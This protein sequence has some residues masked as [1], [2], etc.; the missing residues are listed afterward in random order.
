V[1]VCPDVRILVIEADVAAARRIAELL[2]RAGHGTEI[3]PDGKGGLARLRATQFDAVIT[4]WMLPDVDGTSVIREIRAAAGSQPQTILVSGLSGPLIRAHAERVG[5]DAFFSKPVPERP[6]LDVIASR[7][8]KRLMTAP[9]SK[10]E[11]DHPVTNSS[12]WGA[13]MDTLGGLLSESTGIGWSLATGRPID[14]TVRVSMSMISV[15]HL[16]E[17]DLCL[18]ASIETGRALAR[19]MLRDKS[20]TLP[21]MRDLLRDL[22]NNLLGGLKTSLEKEGFDFT[23]SLADKGVPPGPREF[24]DSLATV[25]THTFVACGVEVAMCIGVGRAPS[26]M[27]PTKCLRENM[28]LAEDVIT[29]KGILVLPHGTRITSTTAERLARHLPKRTV[30][31]CFAA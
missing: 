30:R 24:A 6:L 20:P 12:T 14:D 7:M 15:R 28:V 22:C 17:I 31:V 3:A 29:D 9:A 11:F 1:A 18:Y 26:A 4:D 16:V 2:S 19:S 21:V 8:Q 23:V 10:T 13:L 27:V 5:A 25:E